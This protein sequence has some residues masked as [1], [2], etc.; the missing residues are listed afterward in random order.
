MEQ[1]L[2]QL[3]ELR[4]IVEK[5]DRQLKYQQLEIEKLNTI[6]RTV[7]LINMKIK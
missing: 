7:D 4:E 3:K 6:A 1:I 5:Q 2:Q